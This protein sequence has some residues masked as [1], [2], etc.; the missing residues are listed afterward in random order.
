MHMRSTL[1]KNGTA[2]PTLH[3]PIR[4]QHNL[5]ESLPLGPTYPLQQPYLYQGSVKRVDFYDLGRTA[6]ATV[7]VGGRE[8]PLDRCWR[9]CGWKKKKEVIYRGDRE[10]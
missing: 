10:N 8:Q 7:S 4:P 9:G 1:A 2:V 5:A 3:L 6:V